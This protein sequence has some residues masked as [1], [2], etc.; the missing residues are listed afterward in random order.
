MLLLWDNS[1][2]VLFVTPK[3]KSRLEFW[4]A[5][6]TL[7]AGKKKKNWVNKLSASSSKDVKTF[8]LNNSAVI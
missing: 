3:L 4:I 1:K 6:N 8:L 7:Y 2:H 5:I